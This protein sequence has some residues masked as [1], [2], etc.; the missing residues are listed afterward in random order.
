VTLEQITTSDL[1][2][3]RSEFQS[4]RETT[5]TIFEPLCIEDAV[6]QSD[7]FGSPP[8]WHLAH[9]TWFF[10]K[11]L[12]KY[13][14]K[15]SDSDATMNL[16]YLNSYYQRFQYI[17]PKSERGRYP[18]PTVSQT[19]QYRSVVENALL[20]FLDAV[21]NKNALDDNCKYDIQLGN[22]HEMQHQELMIYDIQHYFNRFP[23]AA[24]N[25][26]P[27]MNKSETHRI[28]NETPTGMTQVPGGLYQLG[29]PSPGFSYDNELPE[30]KVFLHAFEIDRHPVTNG[31][32]IQ[33]IENGGYEDYR[34]WLADGW[35][36]IKQ[37]G[38]KYPLYWERKGGS[39]WYKKDLRGVARVNPS[40]PVVNLSYFEA[41][42]YAKWIGKRL[43]TEAEWEKASSW[44]DDL[45]RKTRYPWGDDQ[46]TDTHANL[47]ESWRWGPSP[48]GSY[49]AGKSFYGC[50]QMIGD[51]W[52]WTSS[53]Y[54]LY[55]NFRSRFPEYTDKWAIGHKVLRG[56]SFA[57]ARGQIRSSYRNY[58]K[59]F[60]RILFAGFRCA[61][62]IS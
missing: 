55:P 61:R 32:F 34:Y 16:D 57:T 21:K 35:D 52:E 8:N 53:E 28:S 46:P 10:H 25:Y 3:L 15:I 18:R 50:Y 13:G 4:V 41:D 37:N 7:P 58:F 29:M 31:D 22:Q 56:G 23:D 5:M 17:L 33:F 20:R 51:V 19:K 42:A 12:E 27:K 43:P 44:N 54:V 39:N 60:E 49:P 9:V 11:I 40:E 14:V 26:V 6:I 36:M 45:Q 62:D 48:I 47:L 2:Q 1:A 38:L 59:P 30:H 24:D